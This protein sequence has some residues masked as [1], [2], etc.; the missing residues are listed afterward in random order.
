MQS[1]TCSGVQP[2]VQVVLFARS[3]G[4]RLAARKTAWYCGSPAVTPPAPWL[5]VSPVTVP[6]DGAGL[7]SGPM[8]FGSQS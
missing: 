2:G 4:G 3:S 6:S 5:V 8:T 7:P 1:L